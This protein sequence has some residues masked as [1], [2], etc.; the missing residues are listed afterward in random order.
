[1][2]LVPVVGHGSV[3]NAWEGKHK[4]AQGGKREAGGAEQLRVERIDFLPRLV[5][6]G[7]YE[8]VIFSYTPVVA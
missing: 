4:K 5:I 7:A 1:L 8:F 6:F 2:D 3:P